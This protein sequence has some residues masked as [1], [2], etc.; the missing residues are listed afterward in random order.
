MPLEYVI[1]GLIF[2]GLT[3]VW[4]GIMAERAK[5]E[6]ALIAPPKN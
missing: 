2:T 5:A 1:P 4:L 6:T 3:L